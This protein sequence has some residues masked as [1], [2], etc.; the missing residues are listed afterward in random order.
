M[1]SYTYKCG[2][3]GNRQT[4]VRS[5]TEP[6]RIVLCEKDG[7]TMTRDLQSDFGKQQHGDIW[8]LVSYAAGVHPDQVPEMM[9]VDKANGV[10]TQYSD[11]GDPTF[12]SR[13]HRRKY[14]R[15]HG[16]H[17]RNAGYGDPVP[18]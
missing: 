15:V 1:P 7:E 10:P 5:M 11:E 3:C 13:S 18:D 8:P 9:A 17:D 4:V 14:C 16:I 6:A 2:K 12:T